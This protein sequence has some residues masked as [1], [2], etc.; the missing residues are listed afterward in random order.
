MWT[1]GSRW[2]LRRSG[3]A[4]WRDLGPTRGAYPSWTRDGQS[5]CWLHLSGRRV[6]CLSLDTRQVTPLA[7]VS[8][9]E[10]AVWV[11]VPWMGLDAQDRPV[12]T[13]TAGA[14][15]TIYAVDWEAP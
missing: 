2:K 14:K 13:A 4:E 12:V 6:E 3:T 11:V 9:L 15:E 5:F 10:L 1:S 7:D 8:A